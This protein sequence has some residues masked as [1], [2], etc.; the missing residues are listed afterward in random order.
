MQRHNL[1]FTLEEEFLL[2]A[3]H[4]NIE[5][6][7]LAFLINKHLNISL[8]RKTRDL[9]FI[10]NDTHITYPIYEYVDTKNETIYYLI[11]NKC[12]T[13]TE[14]VT[15]AGSLFASD[16][17]EKIHYLVPEYKQT[18]FLLKVVFDACINSEHKTLT[19]LTKTPKISTYYEI[20]QNK[21]KSKQNLNF[22]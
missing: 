14:K 10:K 2:I 19:K 16:I 9:D 7:T 8:K 11:A 4:S 5:A 6:H 3:I 18:D 21:L 20:D 17:E 1:N 12:K 13:Q 15:S 22:D